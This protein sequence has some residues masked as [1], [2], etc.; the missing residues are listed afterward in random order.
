M[1]R[2]HI[3]IAL[4]GVPLL[5]SSLPGQAAS[6]YA[7]PGPDGSTVVSDTASSSACELIGDDGRAAA[8]A[9]PAPSAI[10]MPGAAAAEGAGVPH[11]GD[12]QAAATPAAGAG[13]A[14]EAGDR[15]PAA[16]LVVPAVAVTPRSGAPAAARSDVV[17]APEAA[18]QRSEYGS[19]M[20]SDTDL[21]GNPLPSGPTSAQGRRYKMI[22]RA[23]YQQAVEGN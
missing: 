16:A 12:A 20:R 22:D 13:R 18:P 10:A 1:R 17:V 21:A 6:V 19:M 15:P 14:P 7:C 8:P 5:L 9:V 3:A 2:E 11:A 23:T 4:L